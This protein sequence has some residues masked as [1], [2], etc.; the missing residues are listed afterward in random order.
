MAEGVFRAAAA[1]RGCADAFVV[2][3][4]GVAGWHFGGRP[5]RRAIAVCAERGVDISG[6][7]GRTIG[8]E[9]FSR[10][11]LVLAMDRSNLRAL[12]RLRPAGAR[13]DQKMLASFAPQLGIEEIEDP[14]FG[15]RRRFERT[16]DVIAAAVDG[17][18]ATLTPR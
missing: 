9:D 15:R 11:D 12:D 17:L 18:L 10:F 7:R 1:R 13:A 14:Y 2:D 4:A 3:S 6:A 5:D 16:Y 8:V